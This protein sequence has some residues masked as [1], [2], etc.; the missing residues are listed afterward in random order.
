MCLREHHP[1]LT[2]PIEG[3]GQGIPPPLAAERAKME[4]AKA[5]PGV[6]SG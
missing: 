4:H 6:E 5:Q 2:S 3:E 1:H